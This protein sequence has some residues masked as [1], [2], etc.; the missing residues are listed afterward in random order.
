[1]QNHTCHHRLDRGPSAFESAP[2]ANVLVNYV[3]P[4]IPLDWGDSVDET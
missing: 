1:M 3:K 4:V 2:C